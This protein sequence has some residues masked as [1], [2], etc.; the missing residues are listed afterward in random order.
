MNVCFRVATRDGNPNPTN[1]WTQRINIHI[2]NL[3][4]KFGLLIFTTFVAF[5]TRFDFHS[6]F[7][8]THSFYY[9]KTLKILLNSAIRNRKFAKIPRIRN[10]W[11]N[12]L[13]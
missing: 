12:P 1:F 10:P 4:C 9:K 8:L 7:K 3:N 6:I 11:T 2:R 5:K 13:F